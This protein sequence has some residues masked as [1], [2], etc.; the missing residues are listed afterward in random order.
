MRTDRQ[1]RLKTLTSRNF[2]DEQKT[3]SHWR[4]WSR[5]HQEGSRMIHVVRLPTV[6]CDG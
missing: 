3:W 6:G 4:R 5:S 2:V 1:T